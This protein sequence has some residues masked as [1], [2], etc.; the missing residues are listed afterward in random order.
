MKCGV[1]LQVTL[2]AER[3]QFILLS[4]LA[5]AYSYCQI[6]ITGMHSLELTTHVC[7]IVVRSCMSGYHG[8]SGVQL[9]SLALAGSRVAVRV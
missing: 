1:E 4:Q 9:L 3:L 2:T 6:F 7:T 5:E 8:R